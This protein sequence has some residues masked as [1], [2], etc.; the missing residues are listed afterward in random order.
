[1]KRSVED[2]SPI[3][4][5]PSGLGWKWKGPLHG[6]AQ[7]LRSL[8]TKS[9]AKLR[10][11]TSILPVCFIAFGA[12]AF[13]C[14]F[15]FVTG[16]FSGLSILPIIPEIIL[17]A[18]LP[19]RDPKYVIFL[20]FLPYV[21]AQVRWDSSKMFLYWNIKIKKGY[22][23]SHLQNISLSLQIYFK[24][25]NCPASACFRPPPSTCSR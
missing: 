6:Q 7:T 2:C 12:L 17:I 16:S 1:M 11:N 8:D 23:V 20:V 22:V 9:G 5:V 4:P 19:M 15:V 10:P 18:V 24:G 13:P 25:C 3:S 14:L 21:T